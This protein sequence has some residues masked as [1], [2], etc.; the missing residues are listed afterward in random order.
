MLNIFSSFPLYQLTD[1]WL[2]GIGLDHWPYQTDPG[3]SVIILSVEE[4]LAQIKIFL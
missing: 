2:D 1:G 4:I 3:I